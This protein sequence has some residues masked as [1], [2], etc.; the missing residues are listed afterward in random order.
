MIAPNTDKLIVALDV[1]TV[2]AARTL[3][4]QLG[5]S[6]SFY[7]IGMELVYGGGLDFARELKNAGKK[8]FIDLKLHDIGATVERAT[9]QI[10]RLEADFLTIHAYP[11]TMSAA[12]AGAGD[13]LKILAV[14]VLTSYNAQDLED[15]GY[16]GSVTDLVM[17]RASQARATKIDGLILS[18]MEL[19]AVR[20]HIGPQML[21]VTPG[22]RPTGATVNDQKRVMTP[23]KAI[24]AGADHLVIGRP[25]SRASDPRAA[26]QA[27]RDEILKSA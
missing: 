26:A 24:L 27:V 15:A 22:V 13:K 1:E 3:V 6:V 5:D 18:P 11:Q 19:T 4:Q 7:K 25:I 2:E 17:R 14:T 9:R 20:A 16:T 10:A 8:I 21:L 12:R 23:S